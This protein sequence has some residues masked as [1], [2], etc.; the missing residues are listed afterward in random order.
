VGSELSG[1]KYHSCRSEDQ[2]G[3]NTAHIYIATPHY[4]F[5]CHPRELES[6]D[7]VLRFIWLE[8]LQNLQMIDHESDLAFEQSDAHNLLKNTL[9][10]L[11]SCSPSVFARLLM[12]SASHQLYSIADSPQFDI[13]QN[14]KACLDGEINI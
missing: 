13:T 7:P 8:L 5:L 11:Q 9:N 4:V 3:T 1:E 10:L 14:V 12:Y 6:C 2:T